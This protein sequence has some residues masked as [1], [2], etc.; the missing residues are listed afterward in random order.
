MAIT[1]GAADSGAIAM[2]T[3]GRPGSTTRTPTYAGSPTKAAASL[4]RQS[5]GTGAAGTWDAG[6]AS[7]EPVRVLLGLPA[8]DPDTV[9]EQFQ[10]QVRARGCHLGWCT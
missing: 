5:Y 9:L 3:A 4:G 2:I 1:K 10:E 7:T 6:A 8:E